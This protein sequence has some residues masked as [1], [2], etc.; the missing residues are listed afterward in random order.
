MKPQTPTERL[1]TILAS[2]CPD[3]AVGAVLRECLAATT[4]TKS[5]AVEPDVRTRLEAAKL[6]LGYRHGL[7]VRREES[8][9]VNLDADSMIGLRERLASSPAMRQ[10]LAGLL[11]EVERGGAMDV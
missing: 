2:E 8:I 6:V 10:T 4:L 5:G 9:S 11:A 1:A 7:P 3:E